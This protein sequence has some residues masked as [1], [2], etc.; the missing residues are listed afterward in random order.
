MLGENL[1]KLKQFESILKQC[2]IK[3]FGSFLPEN[4][5]SLLNNTEYIIGNE[6]T[7][8]MDRNTFQGN[9]LRNMLDSLINH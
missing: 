5:V 7:D 9:I 1:N 4:K 3:R 2:L 6:F 8:G